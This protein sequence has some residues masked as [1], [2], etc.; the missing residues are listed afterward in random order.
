[1][2]HLNGHS[3]V[4]WKKG[5]GLVAA[6]LN[7]NFTALADRIEAAM[8]TALMP[9]PANVSLEMQLRGLGERIAAL[10]SLTAMHARQRNEREWAPLSHLGAVLQRVNDMQ[11]QVENA[12]SRIEE[13]Y[14]AL[15]V[16]H[17][18]LHRRILRI[19]QQPEAAPKEDFAVLAAHHDRIALKEHMLLA[20]V[21]ALRH[22]TGILRDLALG[23]DRQAN[24][25]EFA[26]MSYV[27]HL[28]Q[29]IREIEERLNG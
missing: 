27:G 20:Q 4:T 23:K 10:E 24:R 12:V 22:E 28:L 14:A 5:D 21:I 11:R 6:D 1:M 15:A 7:A 17:D 9:D 16:D 8:A 3:L 2:G 25:L 29:R 13:L 26:P 18:D 19:E